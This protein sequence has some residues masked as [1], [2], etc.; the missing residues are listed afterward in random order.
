MGNGDKLTSLHLC[1]KFIMYF[2]DTFLVNGNAS[3][4][5]MGM[6]LK[7]NSLY[8]KIQQDILLLKLCISYSCE[9]LFF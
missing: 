9:A 6:L 5:L 2:I 4:F 3:L 1:Y 8:L 7:I